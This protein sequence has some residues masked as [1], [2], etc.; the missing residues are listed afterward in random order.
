MKGKD[1]AGF[2]YIF[3][4]TDVED[5]RPDTPVSV[6]EDDNIPEGWL[7]EALGVSTQYPYL[8]A[9]TRKKRDGIWSDYSTP[10]IWNRMPK[11]GQA[12]TGGFTVLR[13]EWTLGIEWRRD[14]E[15]TEGTRYL[16][17]ALI[18]DNSLDSGWRAYECLKTHE[19][20]IANAPGNTEFW[21]EFD[22]NTSAI[23]AQLILAK[24]ARID[25]LSNNE[26]RVIDEND[27]VTAAISGSG[28]GATGYRFWAGAENGTDAPFSVNELEEIDATSGKIGNFKIENGK[29]TADHQWL[30]YI[31]TT[32]VFVT[33]RI[34]LG[35]SGLFV[36]SSYGGTTDHPQVVEWY[37][38]ITPSGVT[39]GDVEIRRD[40]IYID[41]IQRL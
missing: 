4:L 34:E 5:P 22:I 11:D 9:S 25:F 28:S 33:S 37:S 36:F 13:F 26:L 7:D 17:V 38:K 39:V 6:Q 18:R 1:G 21:R 41:G 20:T 31:G 3:K 16:Y 24:N 29:L 12:G 23:I 32:L 35:H 27:R 10:K 14:P 40:G 30:T 8:W 15:D 2:E 19:S